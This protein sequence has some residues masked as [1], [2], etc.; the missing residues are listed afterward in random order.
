MIQEAQGGKEQFRS[1]LAKKGRGKA[2]AGSGGR[3]KGAGALA[4]GPDEA[5]TA[6]CSTNVPGPRG[7]DKEEFAVK[8]PV[9][10]PFSPA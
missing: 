8:F 2:C 6:L 3:R 10:L 7:P 1:E 5:M 4:P 9:P